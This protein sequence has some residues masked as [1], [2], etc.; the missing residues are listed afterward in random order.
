M[1]SIHSHLIQYISILMWY[2]KENPHSNWSVTQNVWDI[3]KNTKRFYSALY[4]WIWILT[5]LP[6]KFIFT[7]YSEWWEYL[8]AG[9]GAITTG[10]RKLHNEKFHHSYS[11]IIINVRT[12]W[13]MFTLW[14]KGPENHL[15]ATEQFLTNHHIPSLA[16][17]FITTFIQALYWSLFWA[18]L[19]QPTPQCHFNTEVNTVHPAIPRPPR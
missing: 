16:F 1:L 15:H 18:R 5:P 13:K 12:R 17:R 10:E 3:L 2:T 19:Y 14:Y 8:G 9:K 6:W 11:S 4:I 7:F